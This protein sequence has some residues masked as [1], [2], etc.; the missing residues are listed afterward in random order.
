MGGT[1]KVLGIIL[2]KEKEVTEFPLIK[3]GKFVKKMRRCVGGRV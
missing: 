3:G 2:V 1:G